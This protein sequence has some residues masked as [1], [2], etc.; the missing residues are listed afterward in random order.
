M[1][2]SDY[3]WNYIE[4]YFPSGR[5]DIWLSSAKNILLS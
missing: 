1:E 5:K 3:D 4:A 2:V